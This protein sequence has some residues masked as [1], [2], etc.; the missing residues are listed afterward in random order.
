MFIDTCL[1]KIKEYQTNPKLIFIFLGINI[2]FFYLLFDVKL[3]YS[4]LILLSILLTFTTGAFIGIFTK[5]PYRQIPDHYDEW[6]KTIM[7]IFIFISIFFLFI[8]HLNKYQIV[9]FW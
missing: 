5:I 1:K 9:H 3:R 8:Y 7:R 2:L 6:A 4:E